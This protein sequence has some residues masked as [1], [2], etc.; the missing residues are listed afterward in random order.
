MSLQKIA[1]K[2][3]I[4]L[5]LFKFLSQMISWAVTVLV[6]RILDPTDYGLMEL[7]TIV[8]GYAAFFVDMGLG[9]AIIQK[10]DITQKELS[11]VFWFI[12]I[13]SLMLTALCHF[14]AEYISNIF[15]EPRLIS[16]IQILSFV[17]PI[18]G[19][20]VVP[21]S[22][23]NKNME[24]KTIGMIGMISTIVSC[25][26]MYLVAINDGGVWTLV[27][28]M[29]FVTTTR[30]IASYLRTKWHPSIYFNYQEAKSYMH[31]GGNVL[32][33][34]TFFYMFEKSD[35]FFAGRIWT[36]QS[37]G[38]YGFAL[39][40]AQIPTEKITTLVNQVSYPVFSKLQNQKD[41]FNKFYLN[42][43]KITSIIVIPIFVGG[44]MLG[45]EL[46]K[47]LLN[48]KWYPIIDIFKLLCL[49]QILTSLN[50]V[51]SFVHYAQGRPNWSLYFHAS[52][53]IGM[54]VSFYLAVPYGLK[55][56]VIPWFS[57]YLVLCSGWT[58]LTL[59]K[60]G[61][62]IKM[63]IKNMSTAIYGVVV[64]VT[65]LAGVDSVIVIQETDG[66][67]WMLLAII[68]KITAG[69]MTYL[70]FLMLFDKEIFRKIKELKSV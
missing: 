4:W 20:L 40:L 31:F 19:L 10:K 11:S 1:F 42:V 27:S 14:S 50:A 17:F 63:Y 25:V 70:A 47:I 43:V 23:L 51:N 41:E 32:A 21:T 28:G 54:G 18:S 68:A 64:M 7:A 30:L 9:A 53:A 62:D 26:G 57:T 33:G 37:L 2:G 29:F 34:R 3:A 67:L 61:I 24:F 66:E 52:L 22:L 65:V 44:F 6:A 46:I 48:E 16:I 69:G 35:K 36:P 55:G 12:F 58:T 15:N 38:L 56:I 49:A 13:V 39:Q 45:D 59:Y 60:M 5:A 8:T